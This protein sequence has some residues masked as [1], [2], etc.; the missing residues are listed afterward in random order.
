[1]RVFQL[2]DQREFFLERGMQRSI[3]LVHPAEIGVDA[4]PGEVFQMLLRG[5][6]GRHRLVRVLVFQLI[7]RKHDA[8]RKVHGFRDSLGKMME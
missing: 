6:A 4:G 7:H 3:D 5:L 2:G 8:I 1:M